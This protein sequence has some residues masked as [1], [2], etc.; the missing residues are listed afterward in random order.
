MPHL[1]ALPFRPHP[2]LRGPHR[3]TI[4]PR[5][6][7]RE[8]RPSDLPSQ[9]RIFQI[10]P[11]TGLL[12]QCHWQPSP[13]DTPTV[14]LIHGLEG[15]TESHY[16]IGLAHKIW[17]KG[18]NCIRINQ[19]N[20]GDSEHLTPTLYHNG[21]SQ[22]YA[23]IIQ[24]ITKQDG[25]QH[26]WLIGYSMG[27]NLT[28]KLAGERGGELTALRGVAAVSPNIQPAACVR[29]LQRQ[30]NWIYHQHFLRSLKAKLQR[31]DHL[32]PGK[33]DL[34]QLSKIQTMWEFDDV[35]TAPD[36]G[37]QHAEDYYEQS[38][39]EKTL[40]SIRIP[41]LIITAQNDP[42]I[43]YEI[44]QRS[45]LHHNFLIELLAPAHGGH[46]GFLQRHQAHEDP[47]WAENRIVDWIEHEATPVNRIPF[48][49]N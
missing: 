6:W 9:Q 1:T 32:Y 25:C 39:A 38:A 43:P 40:K 18:W 22:D 36:G 17:A 31:K 49:Q 45:S 33:W 46:C 10:T 15:C 2:L 13:T 23:Q 3:M 35:Y 14:L 24:E 37:Y 7:P 12:A 28:L 30:S 29:A 5:W 8:N 27:G 16:M 48:A 41:T 34:S 44:F 21:L 26:I 11:E 19:R 47:F 20:C 4:F 42:F